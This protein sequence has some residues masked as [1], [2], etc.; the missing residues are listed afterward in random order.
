MR[1]KDTVKTI[2]PRYIA[3][4]A[5]RYPDAAAMLGISVSELKNWV[6]AGLVRKPLSPKTNVVLFDVAGL[7]EDWQALKARLEDADDDGGVNEWDEVLPKRAA[8]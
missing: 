5:V 1:A 6:Q 7:I 8:R 3:P 4:L 2:Q